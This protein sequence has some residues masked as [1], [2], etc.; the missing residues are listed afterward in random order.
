MTAGGGFEE[1]YNVRLELANHF[2]DVKGYHWLA[3]Y[4][5]KSCYRILE[6]EGDEN[7]S[8]KLKALQLLGLL[9][10]RR[11]KYRSFYLINSHVS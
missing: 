11:G 1:N 3:E 4:L 9:E 8:M 6:T 7:C 2:L 5:Y 10:E